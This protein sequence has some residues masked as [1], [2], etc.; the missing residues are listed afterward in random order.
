MGYEQ[1]DDV[2]SIMQP[3]TYNTTAYFQ[4]NQY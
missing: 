2:V 3:L 4:K 1:K